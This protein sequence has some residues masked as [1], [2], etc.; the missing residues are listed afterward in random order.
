MLGIEFCGFGVHGRGHHGKISVVFPA[1]ATDFTAG[2]RN[3]YRDV[4]DNSTLKS[5]QSTNEC[6]F[7]DVCD[8]RGA[9]WRQ[10]FERHFD[11]VYCF[12][13]ALAGGQPENCCNFDEMLLLCGFK[14]VRVF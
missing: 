8:T 1:F 7:R 5:E 14:C 2:A 9:N 13:A 6:G 10:L 11:R 12:C 3:D 4:N